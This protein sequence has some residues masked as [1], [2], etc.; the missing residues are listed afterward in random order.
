M[1]YHKL[2]MA[3]RTKNHSD[4]IQHYF[5]KIQLKKATSEDETINVSDKKLISDHTKDGKT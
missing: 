3:S 4:S 2:E 5:T 1:F